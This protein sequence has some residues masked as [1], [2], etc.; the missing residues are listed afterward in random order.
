MNHAT[1]Q[2]CSRLRLDDTDLDLSAP[3]YM[4][5]AAAIPLFTPEMY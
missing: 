4:S 5:I 1:I 2:L 3:L